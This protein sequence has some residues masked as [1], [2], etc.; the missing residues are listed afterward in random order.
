MK[1]RNRKT[2]STAS[3]VPNRRPKPRPTPKS[4][5][6]LT[7]SRGQARRR[8]PTPP[9]AR[10]L[11]QDIASTKNGERTAKVETVLR[12]RGKANVSLGEL[13]VGKYRLSPDQ[14]KDRQE[15]LA[16]S[17]ERHGIII[18]VVADEQGNI[19]AGEFS[20]EYAKD[21]DIRCSVLLI[22]FACEAEKWELALALNPPTRQLDRA[23]RERLIETYL[24]K[25]PQIAPRIWPTSSAEHPRTRWLKFSR[26]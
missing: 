20:Y 25:D 2:I 15:A 7:K 11:L 1:S 14:P 22:R 5:T 8:G 10:E 12:K 4:R 17:F 21:H 18:P 19:I 6:H 9:Q 23:E 26:S 24:R 3:M 16:A 13:N